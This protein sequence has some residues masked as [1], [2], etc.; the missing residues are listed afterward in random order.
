MTALFEI[1]RPDGRSQAQV[2]IDLVRDAQ[3]GQL[4]E[5]P[6]LI[7]ALRYEGGRPV[8]AADVAS[9]VSRAY[10]RLLKEHQRALHCVRGRGYRVAPASDQR[11]LAQ[12]R[13]N[14]ADVQLRVGL[15]TL[16]HVRW[17]ELDVEARKA[18]EATLMVMSAIYEQQRAMERR[19]N[20]IE[21]AVSRLLRR[22]Q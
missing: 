12:G 10:G 17:D 18:H 14:R 16:R 5:Y 21:E 8:T 3:P 4:F 7:D 19:Q 20:A 13:K 2:L 22:K 1:S 6:V 11:A 9:V 15:N